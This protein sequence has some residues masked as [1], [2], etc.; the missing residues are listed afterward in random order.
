MKSSYKPRTYFVQYPP[1]PLLRVWA[2]ET[3]IQYGFVRRVKRFGKTESDAG[4]RIALMTNVLCAEHEFVHWLAVNK[5]SEKYLR[6]EQLFEQMMSGFCDHTFSK[7]DRVIEILTGFAKQ[8]PIRIESIDDES[9]LEKREIEELRPIVFATYR[10]EILE[11]MRSPRAWTHR[12]LDEYFDWFPQEEFRVPSQWA[13]ESLRKDGAHLW[14]PQEIEVF[15]YPNGDLGLN[16]LESGTD[17]M[18]G[19]TWDQALKIDPDD[20]EPWQ[21]K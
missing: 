17:V 12:E 1:H 4:D 16:V 3:I 5:Y 7:I 18:K 13:V 14:G 21:K 10:R 2:L 15:G 6:N 8:L 11:V 19:E 9:I 20:L